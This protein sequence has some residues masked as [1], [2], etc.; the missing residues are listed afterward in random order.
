MTTYISKT[1]LKATLNIGSTYA[2]A[3]IDR[4]LEAAS[5]CCDGYKNTRFWSTVE[6]RYYTGCPGDDSLD[7]DD[8]NALTSVAV[9]QDG[10]GIYETTWVDGTDFYKDPINAVALGIPYRKISLY[11]QRGKWFPPYQNNVKI[12]ASFGW[13]TAPGNVIQA[14]SIYAA[15]LL[16]RARETPNGIVVVAAEAVAAA[17]IGKIDPDVAHLLDTIPNDK[18]PLLAI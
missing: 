14:T 18:P 2:D 7:V 12:V 1:D 8:F 3:D 10:D 13:A 6:T 4:A 17:R 16:K 5:R 11:R 9:D 15:R